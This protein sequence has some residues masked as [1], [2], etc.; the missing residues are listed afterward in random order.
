MGIGSGTRA[1][2]RGPGIHIR[3]NSQLSIPGSPLRGA[4]ED[5]FLER[6]TD[7]PQISR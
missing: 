1:K 6:T 2:P 3:M 5:G 4:P 7:D